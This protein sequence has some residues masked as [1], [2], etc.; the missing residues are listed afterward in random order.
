MLTNNKLL[1]MRFNLLTEIYIIH[2]TATSLFARR[3]YV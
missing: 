3:R 2:R 1:F